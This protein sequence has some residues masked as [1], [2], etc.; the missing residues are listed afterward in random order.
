[1]RLN[2]V[3]AAAVKLLV[4]KWLDF[5]TSQRLNMNRTIAPRY[6]R[7]VRIGMSLKGTFAIFVLKIIQKLI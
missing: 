6:E 7:T 3:L 1:M 2:F 5:I 4:W